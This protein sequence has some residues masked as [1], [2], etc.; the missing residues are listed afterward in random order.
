MKENRAYTEKKGF[1]IPESYFEDFTENLI[2]EI[3]KSEQGKK[4]R[5]ITM[6]KPHLMLAASMIAIVIVSYTLLKT[7]LPGIESQY[8][9]INQS[10]LTEYLIEDISDQELYDALYDMDNSEIEDGAFSGLSDDI[11]IEYLIDSD[12]D[13]D[14]IILNF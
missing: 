1:K 7:F 14:A 9:P 10:E 4:T 12:I 11:I 5:I 8:I 2:Q 6:A 13:L 3:G